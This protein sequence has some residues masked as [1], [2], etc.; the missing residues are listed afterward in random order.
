MNTDSQIDA[1]LRLIGRAEPP[2]GLER[3]VIARLEAPPRGFTAVHSV[4]AIAMAASIAIAALALGPLAGQLSSHHGETSVSPIPRAVLP[5]KGA[6]GAASAVRVPSSAVPELSVPANHVRGRARSGRAKV[7]PG[8][9]VA[10]SAGVVVPG[11]AV[12]GSAPLHS[13][14]SATAQ[15]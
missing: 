2:Q 14:S 13:R 11:P 7:P 5:P 4:S 10:R 1:A 6:F 8:I 9:H 15:H 3:R 12:L